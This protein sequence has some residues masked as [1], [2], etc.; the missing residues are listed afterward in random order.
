MWHLAWFPVWLGCIIALGSDLEHQLKVNAVAGENVTLSCRFKLS[1]DYLLTKLQIHWHVFRDHAGSVVHSYYDSAD[2][3]QDQDVE[4]RGRTQLFLKELG[5]GV[6][7]LNLSRVQPSDSGDYRCII[8]NSQDVLIGNVILHVKAPYHPPEIKILSHAGGEVILQCM[9][10]GGYPAAQIC[11]YDGKGNQL[12]QLEPIL[13]QRDEKGTFQVQS[14]LPARGH[15]NNVVCCFLLH[16]ALSQNLSVCETVP[17]FL[18]KAEAGH[19]STVRNVALFVG[20]T[21]VIVFMLIPIGLFYWKRRRQSLRAS[22]QTSDE[23][24]DELLSR[25]PKVERKSLQEFL[26]SLGMENLQ[27]RKLK[28]R[29]LLEV[30]QGS[31]K[32]GPTRTTGEIP[33]HFLRKVMALNGTARSTKLELRDDGIREGEQEPNILVLPT[34]LAPKRC[35]NP[36]DILCAVLCCSDPL[37]QQETLLKMSMCQ[38]ALPLVLPPLDT[39]RATFILWALRGIVKRWRPPALRESQGFQEE[40]LVLAALPTFSFVRL[41]ACSLSKSR[42][43]NQVLS[44][45]QQQNDFFIHRGLECGDVPR[46]ISE[47]LVE[48]AWYFPGGRETS[49]PFQEPI[50]V[51]NLRGDVELHWLQFTFLMEVSAAVFVF[52]ESISESQ[53]HRFSCLDDSERKLYFILTPS[54]NILGKGEGSLDNLV[55]MQKINQSRLLVKYNTTNDSDLVKSLRSILKQPHKTA[56]LEDM[57]GTARKLDIQ[58]DEDSEK[59]QRG[60]ERAI[61]ITKEITD[62]VEYK[63]RALKL[64]GEPWKCLTEVERELCQMK[65]QGETPTE[66]YKSQLRQNCLRLRTEQQKYGLTGGVEMFKA[67]IEEEVDGK[68]HYFLRWMTFYLDRISR[69]NRSKLQAKHKEME[70]ASNHSTKRFSEL[71]EFIAGSSLGVEHFLRELGQFYEAEQSRVKEDH[72]PQSHMKLVHLPGLVADLMLHGFPMELVDGGVSNIPLQWVTDVM[73]ELHSKLRGKSRM[74]VVTVLG[75]QS[76]G[77]STLLNTMFGLQFPVSSGRCTRGAFMSL[78][79]VAEDAREDLHCDII[80]LIDTEGLKAPELA[81]L[82]DSYQHDNEL[83][84]LVVGLSDIT[85]VNTAMENATEMQDVL[86]IAVHAFLRMKEIGLKP[87]C[88]FVHQNVSDVS[89]HEKNTMDRKRFLEQL[90]DMTRAAARMEKLSQ[91]LTF[92]AVLNYNPAEHDWYVPSLWHGVPPMASV[93]LGYSESM[94]ELRKH[95]IQLLKNWPS[96]QILEDIPQFLEWVR[97]LWNG[98]KH[99]N[100]L[101]SFRNSRV[102]EA[103]NQ[104]ALKYSEWEWRF[105]KEMHLWVCKKENKIQNQTPQELDLQ[106][107]KEELQAKLQGGE[108]QMLDC[109]QEYYESGVKNLHLIEKYRE[110]F[111]RSIF[112]LKKELEGYSTSK[113]TEAIEIQKCCH[114]INN[115]QAE[116]RKV[117]EGKVVSL[118]EDC[119]NRRHPLDQRETERE[120]GSMWKEAV[121]DLNPIHLQRSQVAQ[122]LELQ[123][124]RDLDNRGSA[125]RQKLQDAGSLCNYRTNPLVMA[126]KYLDSSYFNDVTRSPPWDWWLKVE[127]LVCSLKD[128]CNSYTAEKVHSKADYDETYGR[129]LLHMINE[130]LQQEDVLNYHASIDFEVD[131]KFHIL[132]EAAGKFQEMHT[133]FIQEN[134]PQ[135]RLEMLKQEYLTTFRNLYLEKDTCQ[136]RAKRFCETCLK[137]ALVEHINKQL[138]IRIIDNIPR[139][140]KTDRYSSRATFQFFILKRLLEMMN[141]ADYLKYINDYNGFIKDEIS[142]DI[143]ERYEKKEV[144]EVLEAEILSAIIK[145][146]RGALQKATDEGG[147]AV[148]DFITNFCTVLEN[149]L[150]IPRGSV[151]MTLFQITAGIRQFSADVQDSLLTL[152]QGLASEFKEVTL[153]QKLSR[154]QVKPE[155]ELFKRVFGCGQQC[156]FCGV[157][158]EAETT[159]HKHHY[160]HMHRPQGLQ[161]CVDLFTRTRDYSICSSAVE[162]AASF[163]TK[164]KT[165]PF[166]DYRLYFPDWIISP[167]VNAE[168]SSYWKFVSKKFNHAFAEE[169]ST[170]P[171]H[172]PDDWNRITKEQAQESIEKVYSISV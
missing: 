93:N 78:L 159:D 59:C 101:F 130:W 111:T 91:D 46:Q 128:E 143:L 167:D 125:A 115:I 135:L 168:A 77:K 105:R 41:G 39:P 36:L 98:I 164:E 13:L 3:L 21:T 109:L 92:S 64:Q 158:C 161:R 68:A 122:D 80:L 57:A 112:S 83:A 145:K 37:F 152:E 156:P 72:L 44:P 73:M 146:V 28:L 89:A 126:K 150:A 96:N 61:A 136:Q 127:R 79:Q 86:Q 76:T 141:F 58:V 69:E 134:D 114:K 81:K 171:V 94:C 23:E 2:Q 131:L 169:Y 8:I 56:S 62:V 53:Y 75:V 108:K 63:N 42:V 95:L 144:I 26:A 124:K 35:Q 149:D 50:A 10:S 49:E 51:T 172:L 22:N 97:N 5:Q 106:S 31:L 52:A 1:S 12:N 137:P 129:E 102:A 87:N 110:D 14:H 121:S 142:R 48:I 11:W 119:R 55:P 9:S 32:E 117:L 27:S 151:E 19:Q 140:E 99:E 47:G 133:K 74:L 153:E 154:L 148:P 6:A 120:F 100:F 25:Q 84:T 30:S 82:E 166:R 88:Q 24:K 139:H 155:E 107:L 40:S 18:N 132:G 116:Y 90:N 43:L 33:W 16:S 147:N 4:F 157:H 67:T 162:S 138:G 60:K 163:S 15:Q 66:N 103:Y 54:L 34:A 118:L 123:L 65:Q 170:H 20:I 165:V 70:R 113:Y 7:A 17:A 160:A 104:L 29:D 38:F 85:I 71:D 45:S